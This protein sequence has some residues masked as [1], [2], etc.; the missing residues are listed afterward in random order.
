MNSKHLLGRQGE[1][2]AAS[3]LIQNDYQILEQNY[4]YLKAEVDIIALKNSCLV[5]VE[6]KTRSSDFFGA[7]ETF[8]KPKQ[9]Q[10][11]VNAIDYYVKQNN[12]TI[13]V[14]FDII[15]VLKQGL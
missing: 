14:R 8:L 2:A 1:T 5:A 12:L 15:S 7:P 3:F 10:R 13:E 4:R 6:I 9:Q 11:I